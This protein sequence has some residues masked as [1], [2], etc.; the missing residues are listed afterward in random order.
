LKPENL[1]EMDG[2]SLGNKS[3]I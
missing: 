1:M 2:S 3:N